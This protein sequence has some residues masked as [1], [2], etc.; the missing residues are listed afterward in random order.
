[1]KHRNTQYS[2]KSYWKSSLK[3][4]NIN[5]S[6][7]QIITRVVGVT[8][9]N[10]QEVVAK[11]K[12]GEQITLRREPTNPYDANVIRVERITCEQIGYIDRYKAAT[13]APMYD[14]CQEPGVG[15]VLQLTG[16][17]NNGMSLGVVIEFTIPEPSQMTK[18]GNDNGQSDFDD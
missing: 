1:M 4:A 18:G 2:S 11:L 17:Q 14:A 3:D 16:D 7:T 5:N 8:F 10:R 6:R 9:D 13:L 15:S 12:V